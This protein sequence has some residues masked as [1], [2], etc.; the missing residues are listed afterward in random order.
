M[1]ALPVAAP[2]VSVPT[3]QIKERAKLKEM[4]EDAYERCINNPLEG[5]TE[6]PDA[7][8]EIFQF[9]LTLGRNGA[10]GL[11]GAKKFSST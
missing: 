11:P 2:G 4:F 1:P 6:M 10:G 7:M 9:A 8:E 3:P 5:N